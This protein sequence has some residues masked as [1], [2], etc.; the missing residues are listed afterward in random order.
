[1]GLS[2]DLNPFQCREVKFLACGLLEELMGWLQLQM[3]SYQ[4]LPSSLFLSVPSKL[5]TLQDTFCCWI[6]STACSY[7]QRAFLPQLQ[8]LSG[9]LHAHSTGN[10]GV[11]LGLASP[12]FSAAKEAAEV[13]CWLWVFHILL[14]QCGGWEQSLLQ[15]RDWTADSRISTP[16]LCLGRTGLPHVCWLLHDSCS[17]WHPQLKPEVPT[18]FFQN[19][20]LVNEYSSSS[21]ASL[22]AASLECTLSSLF[23]WKKP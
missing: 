13:M 22:G 4:C 15:S 21:A 16:S 12:H 18:L 2:D 23:F 6:W 20:Y 5:L 11:D 10:R 17:P 7:G 8:A 14:H 1:M 9:K 3:T 19:I